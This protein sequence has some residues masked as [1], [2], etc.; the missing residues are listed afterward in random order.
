MLQSLKLFLLNV[1]K[2][3]KAIEQRSV[4]IKWFNI[5]CVNME[6]MSVYDQQNKYINE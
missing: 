3:F 1:N 6:C 4:N 5:E 2:E